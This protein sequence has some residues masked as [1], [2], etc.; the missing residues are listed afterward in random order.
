MINIFEPHTFQGSKALTVDNKDE[1]NRVVI[2]NGT[3]APPHR[4]SS[5]TVTCTACIL[6]FKITRNSQK[7]SQKCCFS[8]I[9]LLMSSY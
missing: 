5:L 3:H 1:K 8:D 9:R 7:L 4:L 6:L 2:L